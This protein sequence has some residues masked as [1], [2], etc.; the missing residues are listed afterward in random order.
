MVRI[1][2]S[3]SPAGDDSDGKGF[4]TFIAGDAS[5]V[6]AGEPFAADQGGPYAGP[7]VTGLI[8]KLRAW[9]FAGVGQ[10]SWG[11]TVFAFAPDHSTAG[12]L[13]AKLRDRFPDLADVTVT[14]ANNTGFTFT[15]DGLRDY[16]A[17]QAD[18]QHVGGQDE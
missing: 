10:S 7:A 1:C 2:C 17:N 3:W 5:A 16:H 6:A 8:D 14:A 4:P 12:A 18:Q 15:G 9:D 11:P 13:A